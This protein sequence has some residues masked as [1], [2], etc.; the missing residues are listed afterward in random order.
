LKSRS[1]FYDLIILTKAIFWIRLSC[2][3][4]AMTAKLSCDVSPSRAT[5]N[6]K[7][8]VVYFLNVS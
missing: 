4:I 3:Y 2:Y 8:S 5:G 6:P 1:H 7:A